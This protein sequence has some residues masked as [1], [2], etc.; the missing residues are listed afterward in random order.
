ML[1]YMHRSRFEV[2]EIMMLQWISLKVF[3]GKYSATTDWLWR[4]LVAKISIQVWVVGFECKY[5]IVFV[6]ICL[7]FYHDWGSWLETFDFVLEVNYLLL[8]LFLIHFCQCD[9]FIWNLVGHS[10]R[11][12]VAMGVGHFEHNFEFS[13]VQVVWSYSNFTWF[14]KTAR[15]V[16]NT[17]V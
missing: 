5:V 9:N 17:W 3:S 10:I 15:V 7:K 14:F 11:H 13:L 4:K 6:I 8:G 2:V 16:P 1:E 12:F